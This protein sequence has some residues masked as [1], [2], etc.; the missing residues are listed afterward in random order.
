MPS[1][2]TGRLFG[3]DF[4]RE[5]V[6]LVSDRPPRRH[7]RKAGR[8]NL[9]RQPLGGMATTGRDE[10]PGPV[11]CSAVSRSRCGPRRGP[12]AAFRAACRRL[13]PGRAGRRRRRR[14]APP[15]AR[16]HSTASSPRSTRSRLRPADQRHLCS[17]S[18]RLASITATGARLA[19]KLVDQLPQLVR[20]A[21]HFGRSTTFTPPTSLGVGD[22]LLDGRSAL[23]SG[24]RLLL[25]LADLL[26][27]RL[28]AVGHFLGR[29]PQHARPLGPAPSASGGCSARRPGRSGP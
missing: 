20:A 9:H 6:V 22:Q 15:P 19:A 1:P 21:G 12:R 28:D 29:N 8:K 25:Q 26:D 13:G 11:R 14:P 17:S 10:Y 7:G 3:H 27:Q 4:Q 2:V 5:A 18:W 23:R 24:G 16:T